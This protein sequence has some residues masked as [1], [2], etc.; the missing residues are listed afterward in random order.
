MSAEL[1]AA[2]RRGD[3]RAFEELVEITHRRVYSLAFRLTGDRTEAEDVSQEAYLRMFRG[4]A[5]FR[6]EAQFET[7][8]HRIVTNCAISMRKRRGR[9]GDLLAEEPEDVPVPDST[10]PALVERDSLSRAL[11][12]LPEGQRIAVLLKDVYGLSCKEI[13]EELGVGEGAVKVR[14]HRARK[15]LRELLDEPDARAHQL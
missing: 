6:E 9:F 10:A 12:L 4:L 2:C 11:A 13:G 3:R 15:R 8:M 5:G 1:L 7:W 14:L